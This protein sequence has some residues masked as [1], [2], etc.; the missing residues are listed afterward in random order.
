MHCFEVY[1]CLPLFPKYHSYFEPGDRR[2]IKGRDFLHNFCLLE[3][4]HFCVLFTPCFDVC[5]VK[6]R[7]FE[8]ERKVDIKD[9]IRS[10]IFPFL[11][12]LLTLTE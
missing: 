4:R 3:N 6:K 11:L 12:T 5:L 9:S 10:F 1:S 7:A 2:V 8:N